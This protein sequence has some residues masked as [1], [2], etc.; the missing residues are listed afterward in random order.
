MFPF[1]VV[2]YN[3]IFRL[4]RMKIKLCKKTV[5]SLIRAWLALHLHLPAVSELGEQE[6]FLNFNLR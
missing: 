5:L 2:F 1:H 4:T 3:M 6:G